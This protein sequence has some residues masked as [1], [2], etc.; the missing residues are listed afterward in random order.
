MS[1]ETTCR[2]PGCLL[3]LQRCVP[4]I[5]RATR[6]PQAADPREH[7]APSWSLASV[8]PALSMGPPARQVMRGGL[9][10][11]WIKS[12]WMKPA[13]RLP[14]L[15]TLCTELPRYGARERACARNVHR[16]KLSPSAFA[17]LGCKVYRQTWATKDYDP[18]KHHWVLTRIGLVRALTVNTVAVADAGRRAF[19]CARRE[20]SRCGAS[21]AGRAGSPKLP[22]SSGS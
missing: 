2:C 14:D 11:S 3:E 18:E 19:A 22:A 1:V 17:G 7:T 5:N 13:W 8:N 16:P 6:G 4:I 21:A 12:N 10:K 20:N 9:V 15:Y